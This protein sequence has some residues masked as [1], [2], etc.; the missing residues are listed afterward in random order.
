MADTEEVEDTKEEAEEEGGT[1]D[2]EAEPSTPESRSVNRI[3]TTSARSQIS[4]ARIRQEPLTSTGAAL[5][6][7]ENGQPQ[8]RR[9]GEAS[10]PNVRAA[11]FVALQTS[12]KWK[13]SSG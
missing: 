3:R 13:D 10:N 8:T 5:V 4:T 6:P 9:L 11:R 2:A 1:A 7:V 12:S